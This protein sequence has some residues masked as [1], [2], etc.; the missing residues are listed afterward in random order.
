[1]ETTREDGDIRRLLEMAGPRPE[2]PSAMR[3]RVHA[4]VLAEWEAQPVRVPAKRASTLW[5]PLWRPAFAA[6]V[7]VAAVGILL[8]GTPGEPVGHI[9]FA[10]GGYSVRGDDGAAGN[11]RAGSMVRTTGE[12]RVM[13]RLTTTTSVR[14]DRN[15]GATF[16]AANE[17]WLHGG[18]LYVDADNARDSIRI[19]TPDGASIVDIGTQFEVTVARDRLE[20]AVREGAVEVSLPEATISARA[21]DGIGELLVFDEQ[22]GVERVE[23]ATTDA[24]WQWLRSA[25]PEFVPGRHTTQYDF[26]VWAAREAGLELV[27][28]SERALA[29]ARRESVSPTRYEAGDLHRVIVDFLEATHLQAKP[30]ARTHEL[31][32]GFKPDRQAEQT[33]L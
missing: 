22:S 21:D 12:G 1:M 14:L 20:V 32:I 9:A 27:F 16:H 10:S 33:R 11:V 19:V 6:A 4:A 15:T 30:S 2:P 17:I 23:L 8:S 18:R 5:R 29:H 24:R 3:D 25:T 7:L 28:E 31:V 13:V 26:L